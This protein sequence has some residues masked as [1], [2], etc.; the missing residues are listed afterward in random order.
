MSL[1][2]CWRCDLKGI[3]KIDIKNLV[4]TV[5]K[6][7]DRSKFDLDEWAEYLDIL[8]GDRDFQKEAIKT[9]IIYL[10]SGKYNS[11]NDLLKENFEQVVDIKDNYGTLEKLNKHAQLPNILS[12]VIDMATGSGKSFVIFGIAH[13]TMTLGLVKRTLVL[14]PSPTIADGLTEKFQALITDN[15]LINAIPS[16]Y[17]RLPIRIIDANSTIKENDICIENIH[18]VYEK[19]GSSIKDSFTMRGADTLILSDEVHHSYN[20]STDTSIRKWKEFIQNTQYGFHYHL[21]FTGTAYRD[22]DY[23][24]DVIFRYS[25][26]QAIGDKVVK[27]IQY[28]AEDSNGDR[29]EQFQKILQNHNEMKAK[30]PQITPLSIIVTAK[31]EGAKN[32]KEDFV[33]KLI[34]LTGESRE[35]IEKRVLIVTSDPA[36]KKNVHILKNVDE[37]DCGVEWIISVSMLTE[38]WDCKN[39][40]QIV[41]WEDRAF[42]SKLLISQVLGRGLRIPLWANAQP[43]VIVFN[44]SNWSSSIQSIVDEVLENETSLTSSIVTNGARAKHNFSLLNLN[45]DKKTYEEFNEEF[46]KEETFDINQ[47][48]ELISQSPIVEKSTT[49]ADTRGGR[50][51]RAYQIAEETKTVDE[52]AMSIA[53]QFKSRNRE[54]DLRNLKSE[55]VYADGTTEADKLPSYELIKEYIYKC[56]KLVNITGDRLVYKNI[57]KINGKFTGLLRKKRTS[58]GYKN[59]AN[60][61]VEIKTISM[62]NSSLSYTALRNDSTIFYSSNYKQELETEQLE[63]FNFMLNELPRKQAQEVNVHDFKTPHN[64]VVVSKSPE[65]LFVEMLT[66]KEVAQKIDCWIKSRNAA[67][68]SITYILK[69][70][71]NPKQFNPDFFIK[72]GNS[73]I[74]IETKADND[75]ARENYSK[76]IDTKKH[77]TKLNEKLA[78]AGRPERY[79]FNILS[80][81]SYP[82]FEAMLK[83]GTYF[84]GFNSELEDK[85]KTE[86]PTKNE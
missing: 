43:K 45:Y 7:Y 76:M 71:A 69:R 36:H 63:I 86:Y 64:I 26:K 25:L 57:D 35:V 79:Y 37:K 2:K 67:F 80:P 85:L 17:A 19:T 33:D 28:V 68:Y 34:E 12:G 52:I 32:L 77:F 15:N 41:P 29:H 42:N 5:D 6:N 84:N 3:R 14:C 47:P 55:L 27:Y 49:Y 51:S 81:I 11:I 54:A 74:V 40:F 39:V 8:C 21:G 20:S 46:G 58:A 1:Q 70:G 16:R 73:I 60:D 30:Y 31:I 38:G 65:R 9:S 82:T 61:F 72:V 62:P 75:T 59:V 83:D 10:A 18:A 22:N 56:M 53:N 13:I 4:L 23:F 48:V 78:E 66:K 44:H 24:A 50:E